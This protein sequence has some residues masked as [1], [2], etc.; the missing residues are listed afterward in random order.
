MYG[1]FQ[2]TYS[3][4]KEIPKNFKMSTDYYFFQFKFAMVLIS[5]NFKN[6]QQEKILLQEYQIKQFLISSEILFYFF[7]NSYKIYMYNFKMH[8]SLSFLSSGL[9]TDDIIMI[10]YQNTSETILAFTFNTIGFNRGYQIIRYSV[11][12]KDLDDS[13]FTK[14]HT[15][16]I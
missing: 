3:L 10:G 14:F 9:Y 6:N 8:L 13:F 5:R 11:S 4:G 15:S 7:I 2:K 16:D 12:E 1:K